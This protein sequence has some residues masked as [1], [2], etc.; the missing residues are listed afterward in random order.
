MSTRFRLRM[1]PEAPRSRWMPVLAAALIVTSTALVGAVSALAANRTTLTM[2]TQ[3]TFVSEFGVGAKSQ[4]FDTATLSGAPSGVPTPTGTVTFD[5]YGPITYPFVYGPGSCIGTPQYTSTN[6][7]NSAGT[8][9]TSD[10][11]APPDGE[12]KIYLFTANYSGDAVY[13]PV[14]GECDT[15]GESVR[16]PLVAFANSAPPIVVSPGVSP[17][18]PSTKPSPPISISKLAFSPAA[19]A[20]GRVASA[21]HATTVRKPARR[22][23]HGTTISYV[24]SGAGTVTFTISKVVTGLRVAGR[25]CVAATAA[26]RKAL[27]ADGQGKRPSARLRHASCKASQ[28]VGA[29]VRSSQAGSNSFAF[30][31]RLGSRVL[32]PGSYMAD[33]T[34]SPA[35]TPPSTVSAAF[36]IFP[37]AR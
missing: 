6:Q 24:I 28:S 23:A 11:F 22:S 31:G 16:V 33:A 29:L 3:T 20:M 7:V 27:L 21:R 10:A 25:G 1:R 35:A 19:F 30:L 13:A 26:A 12:E 15:P 4:F 34:A 32:S 5:V 9:A 2:S 8:S 17:G 14:T 18:A 36:R 37:A